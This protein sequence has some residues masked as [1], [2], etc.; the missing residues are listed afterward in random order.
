MVLTNDEV[1]YNKTISTATKRLLQP[2]QDLL[3]HLHLIGITEYYSIPASVLS[4]LLTWQFD[5][6]GQLW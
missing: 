3:L 4:T 1:G 5:L 6:H 2:S